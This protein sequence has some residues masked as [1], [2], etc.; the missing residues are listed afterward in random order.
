[1]SVSLVMLRRPKIYD[2]EGLNHTA[3]PTKTVLHAMSFNIV[4]RVKWRQLCSD[5][6]YV[7]VYVLVQVTYLKHISV[8][9]I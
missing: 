2:I 6:R 1:M 7:V 3:H 5:K 4:S 9:S 8:K